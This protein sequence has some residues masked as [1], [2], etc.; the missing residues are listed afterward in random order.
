MI[1]TFDDVGAALA[2][3]RGEA[4]EADRIAVFGSFLTVGAAIEALKR[5]ATVAARHG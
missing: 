5:G 3:A 4:G 2:A 1:R